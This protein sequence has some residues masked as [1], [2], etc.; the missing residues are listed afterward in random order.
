MTKKLSCVL[1]IHD[2]HVIERKDSYAIKVDLANQLDPL[3]EGEVR[4]ACV[5][6]NLV[7]E[8]KECLD[9]GQVSNTIEK[10]KKDQ[11]ARMQK[12]VNKFGVDAIKPEKR[13]MSGFQ[14]RP[15]GVV[16]NDT[17]G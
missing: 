6:S 10:Y 13:D 17:E 3:K 5:S 12:I 15:K 9:C 7:F 11:L 14:I 16:N 1:G 8:H 2:W 4:G